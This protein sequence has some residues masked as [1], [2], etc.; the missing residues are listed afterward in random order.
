MYVEIKGKKVYIGTMD[1]ALDT[2][3]DVMGNEFADYVQHEMEDW[4]RDRCAD[5][6]AD[7][8]IIS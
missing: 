3:R 7:R 2:I 5:C 1:H 6:T 8:G 4:A